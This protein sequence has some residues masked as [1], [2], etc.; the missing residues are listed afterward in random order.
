MT[1]VVDSTPGVFASSSSISCAA[2][3]VRCSDAALGSCRFSKHVAL[4]LV[5]QKARR[6]PCAEEGREPAA[7][8]QQREGDG[9]LPD[10]RAGAAHVAVRRAREDRG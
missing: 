10:Q 3:S 2:A 9:A 5:R 1:L 7:D 8:E 6:Q 4:V